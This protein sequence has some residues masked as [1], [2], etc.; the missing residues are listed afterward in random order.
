MPDMDPGNMCTYYHVPPKS[1]AGST[2]TISSSLKPAWRSLTAKKI[3]PSPP[4]TMRILVCPDSRS[5]WFTGT[6]DSTFECVSSS[7]FHHP[8]PTGVQATHPWIFKKM[9]VLL[10]LRRV[11]ILAHAILAQPLV[12]LFMVPRQDDTGR[13][14]WAIQVTSGDVDVT[15]TL[16]FVGVLHVE[17]QLKSRCPSVVQP[18]K[19]MDRNDRCYT[20]YVRLPLLK[21]KR[22]SAITP[23]QPII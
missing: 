14:L 18:A 17:I 20:V 22:V 6:P 19:Q 4:P 10:N 2:M 15:S 7:K 1:P 5:A 16:Q 9:A 23:C 3:P 8:A 13:H 12:S 11:E 21:V